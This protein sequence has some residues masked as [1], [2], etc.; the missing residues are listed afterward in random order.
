MSSS[1]IH[2]SPAQRDTGGDAGEGPVALG[3]DE[4]AGLADPDSK[5]GLGHLSVPPQ[6][7]PLLEGGSGV[8]GSGAEMQA[9]REEREA[10][11]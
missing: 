1:P 3:A 7:H 9:I 10:S 6:S 8:G 5:A 4:L 11:S 2:S